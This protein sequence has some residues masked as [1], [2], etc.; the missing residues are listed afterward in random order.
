ME[1]KQKKQIPSDGQGRRRFRRIVLISAAALL[2][3][4]ILVTALVLVL[5][6]GRTVMQAGDIK[7]N[8]EM[9]AYWLSYAK[10]RYLAEHAGSRD[11]PTFWASDA[12]NGRTHEDNCRAYAESY[13]AQVITAASLFES[14]GGTLSEAERRALTAAHEGL[15]RY[16][17]G[18]KREYNRRA[19][20]IGFDYGTL[21]KV[22]L[23]E[24]EAELL[25]SLL[26]VE[27]SDIDDYFR[28]CFRHA[29]I[30]E[31]RTE[32]K[33]V[34]D[35][36]GD[37][38]QDMETGE[39]LRVPLT[40][41]ERAEAVARIARVR[42][43]MTANGSLNTFLSLHGEQ[44]LNQDINALQGRYSDGYFFAPSA[45]F[46]A[47]FK[48][49]LPEGSDDVVGGILSEERGSWR[50][51]SAGGSTLFV[52]VTLGTGDGEK[53]YEDDA[54]ADFFHDMASDAA[55]WLCATE[56]AERAASV[57]ID[58]DA[59]DEYDLVRILTDYMLYAR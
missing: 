10:Y 52:Y 15:L 30:I 38:E 37:L 16:E 59:A 47:E 2:A 14:L 12:G 8:E 29:Y 41:A 46:C 20:E 6:G 1:K 7:V 53:P 39:Y 5:G 36:E 33:Y 42:D 48:K 34:T 32:D 22:L 11:L 43:A 9:Y 18:D 51:Y 23:Y 26:V 44:G 57:K 4:A 3:L 13:M 58:R 27:A 55:D 25:R 28:E 31:I 56:V 45:E 19:G 54:N 50:E 40:D 35:A 17:V 21:R 24:K 49:G